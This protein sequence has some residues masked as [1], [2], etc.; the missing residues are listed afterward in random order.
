M[1][2]PILPLSDKTKNPYNPIELLEMATELSKKAIIQ[3]TV[4][5]LIMHCENE[6]YQ[7]Q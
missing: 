4:R 5:A 6:T 7:N 2:Q 1:I 3:A